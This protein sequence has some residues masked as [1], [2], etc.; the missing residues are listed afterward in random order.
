MGALVQD[1]VALIDALGD[2][3][4]I[5]VGHDWGAMASY[6]AAMVA[7][8]KVRKL[9]TAAVPLR[10]AVLNAFLVSPLQP[11]RSWY[12]AFFQ[13]PWAELV[14]AYDDYALIE[15]LWQD[16]SPGW[17]YPA[18]EMASLKE[19]FRQP[20]VTRA[21]IDYYRHTLN[22]AFQFPALSAIAARLAMEP[23]P[24]P[25]L[26]VHGERDG[27]VGLELTVGMEPRFPRG[28][29]RA[30]IPGAGHFVHQEQPDA[31]NAMVLDFLTS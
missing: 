5:L 27:V 13:L 29:Q 3:A 25:T 28:L 10:P 18:D 14:V 19:T 30:I 1:A 4:A 7:P 23:V 2:E 17:A 20:G 31:V 9:V 22:P 6:G 11:L 8:A 21:A 15:Q 26:Y 24:V 12:A 16:W